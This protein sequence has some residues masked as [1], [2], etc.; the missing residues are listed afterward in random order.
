[1]H[2]TLLVTGVPGLLWTAT[3]NHFVACCELTHT[4]RES[5]P[6]G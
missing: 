5:P 3:K 4:E 2:P 1:M 6:D